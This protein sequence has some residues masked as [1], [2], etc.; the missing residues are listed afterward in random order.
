MPDRLCSVFVVLKLDG[1]RIPYRGRSMKVWWKVTIHPREIPSSFC[2]ISF[3]SFVV[4][5]IRNSILLWQLCQGW[6]IDFGGSEQLC[7]DAGQG[8]AVGCQYVYFVG[9][10]LFLLEE[11]GTW[12]YDSWQFEMI[13]SWVR[14]LED[15]ELCVEKSPEVS[16]QEFYL[17]KLKRSFKVLHRI[18]LNTEEFHSH[19]E[20]DYA[21]NYIRAL[22]FMP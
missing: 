15:W 11:M 5:Y 4:F 13:R 19:Y 16:Q 2:F 22:F 9:E 14:R 7:R 10:K 3:S 18:H 21:L 1:Y 12:V 8:M 20:T 17:H 6:K